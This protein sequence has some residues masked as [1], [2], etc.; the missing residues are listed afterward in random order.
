MPYIFKSPKNNEL[1]SRLHQKLNLQKERVWNNYLRKVSK[2]YQLPK[3]K[4]VNLV[5]TPRT[6]M[7]D[8][9]FMLVKMTLNNYQNRYRNNYNYGYIYDWSTQELALAIPTDNGVRFEKVKDAVARNAIQELILNVDLVE[10]EATWEDMDRIIESFNEKEYSQIYPTPPKFLDT[11]ITGIELICNDGKFCSATHAPNS[12]ALKRYILN[13]VI[14]QFNDKQK[15]G[16]NSSDILNIN[17]EEA[18]RLL[19]LS[20]LSRAKE[21]FSWPS[22]IDGSVGNITKNLETLN[23]HNDIAQAAR[24]IDLNL[25]TKNPNFKQIKQNLLTIQRQLKNTA[26]DNIFTELFFAISGVITAPLAFVVGLAFIIPAYF[27]NIPYLGSKAFFMDTT[28][29]F[30]ES[31]LTTIRSLIFPIAMLHSYHT[32]GSCNILKSECSRIVDTL[33]ARVNNEIANPET[34]SLSA[35]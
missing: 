17:P 11:N 12:Y 7:H 28:I 3:E 18:N 24:L 9:K 21:N 27:W 15:Y 4:L 32:T 1:A 35:V 26:K 25:G 31:L 14:A 8:K 2:I 29:C 30:V 19:S 6:V 23:M 13:S 16:K 20:W 5:E 34:N 33:L 22:L 10:R